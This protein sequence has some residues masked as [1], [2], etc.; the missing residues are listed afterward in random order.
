M[1]PGEAADGGISDRAS[2]VVGNGIRKGDEYVTEDIGSS[3][4]L[5]VLA[6]GAEVFV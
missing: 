3:L 4:A 6:C 2:G 1:I 5:G